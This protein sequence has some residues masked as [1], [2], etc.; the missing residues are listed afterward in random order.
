MQYSPGLTA[1]HSAVS[2]E[3]KANAQVAMGAFLKTEA[4]QEETGPVRFSLPLSRRV[5]F[6]Y[7][8]VWQGVLANIP[9]SAAYAAAQPKQNT[10]GYLT[11]VEILFTFLQ[12]RHCPLTLI[13]S[14][15]TLS[16]CSY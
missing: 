7:G 16:A 8:C 14:P 10:G 5:V 15:S 4:D 6:S 12:V 9:S 1:S 13:A 3:E 11:R 2:A